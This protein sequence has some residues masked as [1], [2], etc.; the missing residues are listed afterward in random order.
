MCPP[1]PPPERGEE[2]VRHAAVIARENDGA[3]DGSS[4]V[5]LTLVQDRC[6]Y[7]TSEGLNEDSDQQARMGQPNDGGQ[8]VV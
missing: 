4:A 7:V 3:T 2:A 8:F 6:L 1:T 5:A